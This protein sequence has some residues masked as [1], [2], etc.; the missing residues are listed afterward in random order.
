MIAIFRQH[1]E[2]KPLKFTTS[3]THYYHPYPLIKTLCLLLVR[4]TII[5]F[6]FM[7]VLAGVA[8][9][10]PITNVEVNDISS[11]RQAGF[12]KLIVMRTVIKS[13]FSLTTTFGSE[14]KY[15]CLKRN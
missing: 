8:R 12:T 11:T 4:N 15:R 6:V 7:V 2:R 1:S 13:L 9:R 5:V 14:T 3:Y 10:V